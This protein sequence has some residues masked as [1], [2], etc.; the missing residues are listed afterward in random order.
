MRLIQSEDSGEKGIRPD[1]IR[2]HFFSACCMYSFFSVSTRDNRDFSSSFEVL[3][4]W[5]SLDRSISRC[6]TILSSKRAVYSLS[7]WGTSVFSRRAA[8][9]NTRGGRAPT[10]EDV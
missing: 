10:R 1:L 7:A 6:S 4:A 2:R 3:V 8:C 5:I 9:R